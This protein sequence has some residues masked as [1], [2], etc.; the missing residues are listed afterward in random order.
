MLTKAVRDKRL[1]LASATSVSYLRGLASAQHRLER[2]LR[3]KVPSARVRWRYRIVLDALAVDLPRAT[4][5]RLRKL[6]DVAAV[7]NSATYHSLGST[8]TLL[9][10]TPALIGAPT[11]WGPSLSTAGNGIKIGIIDDGVDQSHPFFGAAGFTP[12]PSFP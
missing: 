6:S 8:Q 9:N 11:L 5:P 10:Q 3:R 1:D 12:P 4:V 2:A 7:Y